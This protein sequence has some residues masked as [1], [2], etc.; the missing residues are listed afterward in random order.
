MRCG[1]E[2][3]QLGRL[4]AHRGA[5]ARQVVSIDARV[6]PG[7]WRGTTEEV[8]VAAPPR[9]VS[10][11]APMVDWPEVAMRLPLHWTPSQRRVPMLMARCTVTGAGGGGAR[12]EFSFELALAPLVLCAG[13]EADLWLPCR[14]RDQDDGARPAPLHLHLRA[15]FRATSDRAAPLAPPPGASSICVLPTC[16]S[17]RD[18]SPAR[19]PWRGGARCYAQR[20]CPPTCTSML[21]PRCSDCRLIWRKLQLRPACAP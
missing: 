20:L 8:V 4:R 5:D 10:S 12:R 11:R 9:S 3:A 6:L 14:E 19:F 1:G 18:C 17:S 13:E 16:S 2:A 15:C 7:Q 21:L